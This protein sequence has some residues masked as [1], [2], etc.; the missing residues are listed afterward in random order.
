M[1]KIEKRDEVIR[2]VL[3]EKHGFTLLELLIVLIII[4][5]LTLIA[6]PK[7]AEVVDRARIAEAYV[8]L[9]TYRV[10]QESHIY[11]EGEPADDLNDLK[12]KI[13]QPYEEVAYF[14]YGTKKGVGFVPEEDERY[15]IY[16][17]TL[18]IDSETEDDTYPL[19][20]IHEIGPPSVF[21]DQ[22]SGEHKHGDR[23]PSHS[24]TIPASEERSADEK[25]N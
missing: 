15:M 21:Y 7:Y 25:I 8:F 6:L 17:W 24:H 18:D 19:V 3:S 2:M 14:N 4:G 22:S 11:T 5:L 23:L 13:P 1:L 9:G 16:A 12:L 20:H 10:A